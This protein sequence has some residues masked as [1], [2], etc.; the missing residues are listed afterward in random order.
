MSIA[1]TILNQIKT[2]DPWA[3]AAWGAKDLVALQDGLQ[4]KVGGLAEFKG[5]VTV[6]YNYGTDLYSLEF[7]RLRKGERKVVQSLED[8]YAEDLV[9][10]IDITV[11]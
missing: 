4:F 10:L 9:R 3:L 11:R 5:Y 2:I 1:K 7:F 6:K 8:V